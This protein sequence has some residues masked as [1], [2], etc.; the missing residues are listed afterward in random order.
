MRS[1]RQNRRIASLEAEEAHLVRQIS[2]Q[3]E[4][5]TFQLLHRGRRGEGID[6]EELQIA[7]KVIRDEG[8]TGRRNQ[9]LLASTEAV[10]RQKQSQSQSSKTSSAAAQIPSSQA[11]W[12]NTDHTEEAGEDDYEIPPEVLKFMSLSERIKYRK[13]RSLQT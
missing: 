8:E 7:A 9:R 11:S 4:A 1:I 10:A 2:E 3:E 6:I 12:V 13:K 5:T